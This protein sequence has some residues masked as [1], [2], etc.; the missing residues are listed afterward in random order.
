MLDV[1]SSQDVMLAVRTISL[2]KALTF[3]LLDYETE[4]PVKLRLQLPNDQ[5]SRLYDRV[6]RAA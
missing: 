3:T 1:I 4:P 6:R 2:G 5:E